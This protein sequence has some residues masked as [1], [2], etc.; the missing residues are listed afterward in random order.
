MATSSGTAVDGYRKSPFLQSIYLGGMLV[1]HVLHKVHFQE[2]ISGSEGS[3]L[4][5]TSLSGLVAHLGDIG[6]THVAE[7]LSHF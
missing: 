6:V 4:G 5:E 3:K 1:E 7:L 2:V